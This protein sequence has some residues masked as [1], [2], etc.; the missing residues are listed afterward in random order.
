[1]TI[2]LRSCRVCQPPGAS[3]EEPLVT[4]SGSFTVCAPAGHGRTFGRPLAQGLTGAPINS[5]TR[6]TGLPQGCRSR[7]LR[8]QSRPWS[9]T[10]AEPAIGGRRL[11]RSV[12]RFQVES[13]KPH[14][15]PDR[16]THLVRNAQG[17]DVHIPIKSADRGQIITVKQV[18]DEG[19]AIFRVI[20]GDS[21]AST[22]Y[23]I[24]GTTPI[25]IDS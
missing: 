7:R 4:M 22:K 13:R 10:A 24:P 21:D 1:M 3:N 25:E 15:P 23:S 18:S 11:L 14:A 16:D 19:E 2:G 20:A 6:V 17:I 5:A 8:S 12:C 9:T